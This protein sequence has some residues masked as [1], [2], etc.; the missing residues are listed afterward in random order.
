MRWVFL[1]LKTCSLLHGT[2]TQNTYLFKSSTTNRARAGGC[3]FSGQTLILV[4]PFTFD[5]SERSVTDSRNFSKHES[6]SRKSRNQESVKC[7]LRKHDEP[8]RKWRRHKQAHF[9]RSI[10]SAFCWFGIRQWCVIKIC[11]LRGSN[12]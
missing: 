1:L 2:R 5:R 6:E 4:T 3:G 7:T 11:R 8:T 10:V 12:P 9:L